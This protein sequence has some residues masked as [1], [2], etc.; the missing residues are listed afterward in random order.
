[1]R[2]TPLVSGEI[3]HI[4]NRSTEGIEIFG[5]ADDAKRFL[6]NLKVF[7]TTGESARDLK[8]H[9]RRVLMDIGEPLVD[10]YVTNTKIN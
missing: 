6:K 7:N 3:Y 4:C 8:R 5:T 1:M 2:N 10:V 9:P